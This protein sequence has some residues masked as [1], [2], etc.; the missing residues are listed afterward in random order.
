LPVKYDTPCVLPGFIKDLDDRALLDG[1]RRSSEPH[2]RELHDRYFKRIYAFVYSRIRS[3]CDAEEIVQETFTAVFGSLDN[4]RG[5]SSLLSWIYGIARNTLNN[6]LRKNR[7]RAE[8]LEEYAT[9]QI[10]GP[11]TVGGASPMD[12]LETRRFATAIQSRLESV[13]GWQ[14]EIF[15]MR[16]VEDLS[17]R[18]I[19]QRTNRS[20][21]SVRSSLYRVKHMLVEGGGPDFSGPADLASSQTGRCS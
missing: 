21:D 11:G 13:A 18:E 7:V 6:T 17:I 19:C 1:L 4:F 3:H 9:K 15:L 2:F 20:S 5:Q 14:S 16:H 12:Q 8:H 10:D